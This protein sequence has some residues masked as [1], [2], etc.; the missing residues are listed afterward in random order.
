MS[1]EELLLFIRTHRYV[2]QASV[3]PSGVPQ[4]A[5]IGIAVTDDLEIVFDSV[6]SS[7]KVPNLRI[8]PAASFVIGGWTPGDERTVQYE[9]ITDQ[10]HGPDLER[11]RKIYFDT[12]PDGRKRLGWPGLVHLRVRP[13]W[14]RYSDFNKNPPQIVE[15]TTA[16]LEGYS[17]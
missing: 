7:R 4:A 8:N 15:F 14:I 17:W 5:I 2:V 16:Q 10:P 12:F 11:L 6:E 9:G 1:R 13:T 3:S